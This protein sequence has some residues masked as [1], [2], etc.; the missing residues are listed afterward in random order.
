MDYIVHRG[1]NDHNDDSVHKAYRIYNVYYDY[2]DSLS[3]EEILAKYDDLLD[4]FVYRKIWQGLSEQ[5]KNVIL[6]IEESKTKVSDICSKLKMTSQTFSKY[7]ERL[8]KR[9]LIQ[10]NQHGYIELT[11]PRF[12]QIIRYYSE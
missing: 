3:L 12:A 5:D 7:R 8:I 1:Y 2:K 6:A 9:G 11:L 4:D 10:T